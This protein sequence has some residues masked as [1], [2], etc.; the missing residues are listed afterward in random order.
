MSDTFAL[1]IGNNSYFEPFNLNN[2]IFDAQAIK[3]VFVNL[4]YDVVEYYDVD[5]AHIVE[6]LRVIKEKIKNYKHFILYLSLIHI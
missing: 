5:I 6:V 3:N 2:A 1:I 4:G